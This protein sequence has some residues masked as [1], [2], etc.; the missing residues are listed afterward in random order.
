M[1]IRD[2]G[3][4][5]KLIIFTLILAIVPALIVGVYAGIQ[6]EEAIHNEV[7]IKLEE[8]VMLEKNSL[9]STFSL[10]QDKVNSDLKVARSLFYTEGEPQ[11]VDG[12]MVI[13]DEHVVNGNYEIVDSIKDMVGGTATVFQVIDNQAV[14]V[15]TNVINDEGERAVGTTV[16]QPVY[17][18]VVKNGETFYGRA[19]VVN[20]WYLTAY[21]PIKDTSGEIIGILYVGVKE[22]PFLSKIKDHFSNIVIGETGYMFI[23]D[24]N[25]DLIAHP[26]MEGENV[27]DQDFIKEIIATKEGYIQYTWE[28]R[29]K[30]LAYTY[31]EDMDW[32]IAS[33][34]YLED[35]EGSISDIKYGV[36]VAILA[37][38]IIGSL[39]A[40][41]FS[42]TLTKPIDKMLFA[43]NQI[44]EGDLS[45]NVADDSRDEIGQLSIAM[46]KM[47]LHLRELVKEVNNSV[48]QITSTSGGILSTSHE[49]SSVSNQIS[50]TI[51]EIS[52]GAQSQ[53]GRADEVSKAMVDMTTNVQEIASSAQEAA[54]TATAASNL[55]REVGNQSEM[56]LS[57]MDEIQEASGDSANVIRELD[58]KS[59]E[60]GEIVSLIT[61]IADQTNLLA[62]NA[63]IEA[64]RAGDHGKGFAVVADE[65]RKLAEDSGNAAQ[66]ISL[67]IQEIQ[68]GTGEA[69]EAVERGTSTVA[70]G[71]AALNETVD[72]VKSIVEG[73]GKV[74]GMAQNI[75]ASAQE[76]SA[77]IQEIT[78]SLEEVSA[79]SESSAAG[80]EEVAA[81]IEEQA[82]SMGDFTDTAQD[83][84]N[85]A[86]ALRQKLEMFKIESQTM[87]S[88]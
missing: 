21:E 71:A 78:A 55:I 46:D 60:I 30:V 83:L 66:Q 80:T 79:V 4:N 35:F 12:E 85:M 70:S 26:T 52:S 8:Q 20:A 28:G 42:R 9:E 37:V 88:E 13:G 22:E 24:S 29:E 25:G 31:Y 41:G 48:N 87:E 77:S 19:W 65:V 63:A 68:Q 1:R 45:V 75:A 58:H 74:A 32:F 6:A 57:Q 50:H 39:A 2:V 76:Q 64:A 15:S 47:T 16:S 14:R 84:S 27:Y 72:A 69:V 17:D 53:S 3:L 40:V 62:L 11:I 38:A 23:M 44:A 7:Q 73:G 59:R 82:S 33:G 36:A 56:L 54:E 5:K 81:A 86:D 10:A 18:A 43:A 67:L 61:N 51:S 49:M 34:S